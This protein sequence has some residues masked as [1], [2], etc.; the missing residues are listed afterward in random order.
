MSR[1]KVTPAVEAELLTKSK[2]WCA[3]C[4]GLKGL[5]KEKRGQIAHINRDSN[6]SRF[7]NLVFLC[8]AHHDQYDSKTS[9]SKN[10]TR[11]EVK[12]YRDQIYTENSKQDYSASEIKSLRDYIRKYSAFFEYIFY[13]YND[14][15]FSLEMNEL[16][17]MGYLR[18]TWWTAPERSFN[19]EIQ[20]T[21]DE[22]ARR[23]IDIRELFET[24]MY[25]VVGTR[26]RFDTANFS[27]DVLL[28]KK[29][30][31]KNYIDQIADNYKKLRAIA[32]I[33][34]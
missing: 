32:S 28:K 4:F 1:T 16:E 26:I 21:Q 2:R 6:D 9:Q 34:P 3:L 13:E 24:R 10:Y 27:R 5:R 30:T 7:E 15:A 33:H 29:E 18:D 20:T 17:V 23:V 22:I 11:A 14:I 19:H 8:M 31:A 25:D 12:K